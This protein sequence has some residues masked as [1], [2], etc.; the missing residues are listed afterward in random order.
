M[1]FWVLLRLKP[2]IPA[3]VQDDEE[4]ERVVH[5]VSAQLPTKFFHLRIHVFILSL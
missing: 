4:T 2:T 5:L 1:S 3:L